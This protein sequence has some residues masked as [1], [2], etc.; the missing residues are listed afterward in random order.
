MRRVLA[1]RFPT[2]GAP[3]PWRLDCGAGHLCV[4]VGDGKSCLARRAV[5]G[6]CALAAAARQRMSG[7]GREHLRHRPLCAARA[8][9]RT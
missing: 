3:A 7:G 1:G 8:G 2:P 6:G 5:T 9:S 4:A